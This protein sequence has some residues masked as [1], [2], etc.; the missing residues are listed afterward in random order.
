[1]IVEAGYKEKKTG[2]FATSMVQQQTRIFFPNLDGLR[3]IAFLSVFINH[4][5]GCLNYKNN[6][7]YYQFVRDRILLSGDMGVNLFF[8]LSGFLITF[9]LIKEKEIY[10]R[11]NI[12]DFYMRRILRIW[13]LYFLVVFVCIFLLSSFQSNLPAGFPIS[14]S[15]SRINPWLYITFLGNFDYLF[16]GISNILIGVLW[17]VSV[18]E[19]FY[20]FWPLIV[21]F[22]PRKY[23]LAVFISI[24]FASVA[25]RF[26]CSN[27][28]SAMILRYH[29]LSS[30]S[31]LATGAVLARLCTSLK[32]T[33]KVR[34]MPRGLIVSVYILFIAILPFRSLIW[35]FGIHYVH[36]ASILPVIFST[37]F[38]FFIL[39]Q[40]YAERSFLKLGRF[41]FISEVGKLT[42][43]MYCYHMIIFF[44]VLYILNHFHIGVISP[45]APIFLLEVAVSLILTILFAKFS[46]LYFEKMFLRLKKH[47]AAIVRS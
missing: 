22:I 13:P 11:I 14:V 7:K 32:F 6:H 31:D 9:L 27:G 16:H 4:A 35:K 42:Y 47:F 41:K 17:S 30:M 12:G 36:V 38:A 33:D 21:A 20:L 23:L 2:K 45:T 44:L 40:N 19:Q 5:A 10:G 29:T 37:L 28:G 25:F 8:V 39:E 18:E 46:Y 3:F 26:Y 1:M 43:G 24:V 34:R 15:V